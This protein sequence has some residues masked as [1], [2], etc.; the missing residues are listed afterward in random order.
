MSRIWRVRDKVESR[1]LKGKDGRPDESM[2]NRLEESILVPV[3][4]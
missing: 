1:D 3:G 4:P 2:Q